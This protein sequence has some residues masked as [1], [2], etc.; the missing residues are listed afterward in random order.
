[1]SRVFSAFCFAAVLAFAPVAMAG[2]FSE[3]VSVRTSDLDLSTAPGAQ[4][5]LRRIERAADRVCG[6]SVARTYAG[7]TMRAFEAC[8]EATVA[9][10]VV[11]LGARRV[12]DAHARS[13]G[14]EAIDVARR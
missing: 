1:M 14:N 5:M 10:A 6:E 3:R 13:H 7:R 9:A 8:R 4:R 12:S 11:E 2:P